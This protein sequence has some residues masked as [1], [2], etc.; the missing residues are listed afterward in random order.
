MISSWLG[1]M[2]GTKSQ[3]MLYIIQVAIISITGHDAVHAY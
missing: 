2:P 3:V 1:V